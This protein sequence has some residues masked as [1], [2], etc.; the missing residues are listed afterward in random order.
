MLRNAVGTYG[1]TG[2]GIG[3]RSPMR[4]RSHILTGILLPLLAFFAFF[5]SVDAQDD[6][7]DE[8]QDHA[9]RMAVLSMSGTARMECSHCGKQE[10]SM[11]TLPGGK[12]SYIDLCDDCFALPRCKFCRMPADLR[13]SVG[14]R[15]CRECAETTIK[16]P[17]ESK[18]VL[19][20]VRTLL[21]KEFRMRIEAPIVC[22]LGNREEVPPDGDC[23]GLGGIE[24]ETVNGKHRY[25]VHILNE[26]PEDV[27]RCVV[28]H[29]LAH[30]WLCEVLPRPLGIPDDSPELAIPPEI[31]EG[32]AEFVTWSYAK[33]EKSKYLILYSEK[34]AGKICPEEFAQISKLLKNRKKADDWKKNLLAKYRQ[35]N[36]K[37]PSRQA[38]KEDKVKV[39]RDPAPDRTSV[40]RLNPV[41][42]RNGGK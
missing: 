23:L 28:T 35:T 25:T 31:R 3:S 33:A 20:E 12:G 38:K 1:S 5:P 37:M 2:T 29:E 19:T 41:S 42:P 36:G 27:F 24:R 10:P 14:I 30:I 6:D 8:E 17:A 7:E 15:L 34:R 9:T 4:K 11:L 16:D 32:F 39:L 21:D 26:L 22:E 13:T 18:R 40:N